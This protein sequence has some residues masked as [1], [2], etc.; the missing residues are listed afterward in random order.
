M[1]KRE[2]VVQGYYDLGWEDLYC[3]DNRRV[4]RS[5]ARDYRDTVLRH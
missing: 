3:D 2:Y 1:T 5:I 4:A